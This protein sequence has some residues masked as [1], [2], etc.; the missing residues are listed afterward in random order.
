MRR[1]ALVILGTLAVASPAG[2]H[3]APFS[4]VDV[5]MG[6][7]AVDVALVAHVHDLAHDLEMD[8]P[9]DLLDSGV[10]AKRA[11]ALGA[12]LSSR[13]EISADGGVLSCRPSAAP[14]V[15]PDQ[16]SV[17]LQFSCPTARAAGVLR[18]RAML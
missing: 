14:S 8:D 16:Q 10:V 13:F 11:P 9:E 4:Y 1:L 18:V 5:Y 17:R 6:E 12:L 15:A 3:P 7:K 2:A